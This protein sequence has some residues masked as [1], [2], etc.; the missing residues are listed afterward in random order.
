[1]E[2]RRFKN[3]TTEY[4]TVNLTPDNP[5]YS[6]EMAHDMIN[7][8]RQCAIDS[9]EG[10]LSIASYVVSCSE[11]DEL[12]RLVNAKYDKRLELYDKGI[13]QWDTNVSVT[14]IMRGVKHRGA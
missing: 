5:V 14:M 2:N 1:M 4:I 9:V 13:K 3:V 12:K 6:K 8:N 10:L 11:V 7:A